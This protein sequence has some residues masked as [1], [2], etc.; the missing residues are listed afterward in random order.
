M[1]ENAYYL[2]KCL[3]DLLIFFRTTFF[4]VN[5]FCNTLLKKIAIYLACFQ[6]LDSD[7]VDK[8]KQEE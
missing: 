4:G 6:S 2:A 8:G 3:P 7:R 1:S 5:A